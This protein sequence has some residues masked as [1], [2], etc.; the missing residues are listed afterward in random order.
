[1]IAIGLIL[2]FKR[3]SRVLAAI[4]LL[5]GTF[6]LLPKFNINSMNF[7]K[8]NT[9][10]VLLIVAGVFFLLHI[11]FGR[12][13]CMHHRCHRHYHRCGNSNDRHQGIFVAEE[14]DGD[15]ID[16][17]CVFFNGRRE[18]DTNNFK[19]GEVNCVM[20]NFEIDFTTAQLAAG[21]NVLELNTVF[22]CTVLYIPDDWNIKMSLTTA[23]STV[24]DKRPKNIIHSDTSNTLVI[25]GS[26]VFG[27]AEIRDGKFPI[28]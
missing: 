14:G 8:G 17:S 7:I 20:G 5:L 10:S 27:Y 23:F 16:Y 2:L 24:S 22:G 6:L 15:F 28:T 11:L 1:M 26:V 4:L 3:R 25:N 12:R 18:V 9:L 21:K 19:G 13:H